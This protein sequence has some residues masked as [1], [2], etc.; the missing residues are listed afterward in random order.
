MYEGAEIL[1]DG[2]QMEEFFGPFSE[3]KLDQS[4]YQPFMSV[5]WPSLAISLR[6]AKKALGKLSKE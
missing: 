5:S 6:N 4:R 3:W 2:R 1:A